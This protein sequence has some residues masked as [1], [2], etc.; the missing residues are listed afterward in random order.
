MTHLSQPW[1]GAPQIALEDPLYDHE[2]LD[3]D[4]IVIGAG[5]AGASVAYHCA[6]S[7]YR[8]FVLDRAPLA[9]AAGS[10]NR[11]G[12]LYAKL[13]PHTPLE[14]ELALQGLDYTLQ[15]LHKLTDE[16]SLKK[17]QDWDDCGLLQ[18]AYANKKPEY[19]QQLAAHYPDIVQLLT[20][21][22][23]SQLAGVPLRS[24]GL[25]FPQAGWVAPR[26]LTE[27]LLQHPSIRFLPKQQVID[28]ITDHKK[29][30]PLWKVITPTQTYRSKIVVLA[31][32]SEVSTLKLCEKLPIQSARGQTTSVNQTSP[33]RVVVSG[34]G[35]VAPSLLQDGQCWTTFGATFRRNGV[36][37]SPSEAEHRENIVMLQQN[38][39][40]L[41]QLL[42][43]DNEPLPW[44]AIDGRVALRASAPGS[45]PI[46][47]PIAQYTEFMARFAA[48]R[49]DA[50]RIPD[51]EV[52]WHY[53]LYL[54]TAHGARGMIT[55]PL[56]GRMIQS[57]IG[58]IGKEKGDLP[59]LPVISEAI[60]HA[61][62]PNRFYFQQLRSGKM[63][64]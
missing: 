62:H 26:A 34:E 23:A 48:I 22:Q 39:E 36:I 1:L 44:N 37:S 57:V 47:G 21:R 20:Q 55:A 8:V 31:M 14:N 32:A 52:P 43:V 2:S 63:P 10:G 56:A 18:L 4:I 40:R 28:L 59:L 30:L 53:G 25:F 15:L 41:A 42:G 9:A 27:A 38:S 6:L 51:A 12:M 24:G 11:Q 49:L 35:Y 46:V 45:L 13:S 61:L 17:G 29:S 58:I 16:G 7:G 19:Q 60:Y 3:A 50:K 64:D 33:L 5:I 54:S